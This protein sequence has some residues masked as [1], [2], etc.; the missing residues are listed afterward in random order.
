[1]NLSD[2]AIKCI[3]SHGDVKQTARQIAEWVATNYPNECA[4]KKA[5]SQVLKT[6]EDLLQQLAAEISSQTNS[7]VKKDK[8][9]KTIE[10][11]PRKYYYSEKSDA[12]EVSEAEQIVAS[13]S[14]SKLSEHDMYPKLATYMHTDLQVFTKRIDEKKSA[15]KHGPN[16]NRWLHPDLVGIEDIGRDWSSEVRECVKNISDARAKLWS[17]EA[18]LLINR[19]NVRECFFQAVSNSSWANYGYLVAAEIEGQDTLKELRLLSASHGIGVIKLDVGSPSD[20]QIL[21]PA[22]ER[23]DIDW[24]A[25]NRLDQENKDFSSYIK[26]VRQF[27]QTG[28]MNQTGWDKIESIVDRIG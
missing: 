4:A 23:L 7:I 27:H 10:S 13:P 28:E 18:K 17:F 21:I 19:S 5:K 1:M 15:N 6:D 8:C 25:V 26:L 16:G 3:K 2:T 20:S 14:R 24:D 11:R 9:V 22:T 12:V